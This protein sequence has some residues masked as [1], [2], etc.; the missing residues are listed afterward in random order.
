MMIHIALSI[1]KQLLK[2]KTSFQHVCSYDIDNFYLALK[3]DNFVK[4]Y[5]FFYMLNPNYIFYGYIIYS[6]TLYLS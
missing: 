2:F 4:F 3:E 6:L 5:N 1:S